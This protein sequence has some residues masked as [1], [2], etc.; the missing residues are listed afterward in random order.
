M[1]VI[2]RMLRR[3]FKG[4]GGHGGLRGLVY[5]MFRENDNKRG[6]LVGVD[7][8]G[9]KYFENK[10]DNF[11][12]RH[13]WVV[14]TSEMNGKNTHWDVDASMVPAEWHGWLHSMTDHPPT[15]HPPEPRKFFAEVHQF[16]TSA[17][18]QQYVPYPTTRKKIHEWVPPKAGAQ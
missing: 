2:A 18:P 11:F 6:T 4:G 10:K 1:A 9:N 12:G 5:P 16:N 3:I 14:Y 7:K 8:Y 15:T 13:R 17:T